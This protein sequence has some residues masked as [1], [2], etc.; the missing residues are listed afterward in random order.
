MGLKPSRI[1]YDARSE[2]ASRE[3]QMMRLQILEDSIDENGKA[4]PLGHQR[5][6]KQLGLMDITSSRKIRYGKAWREVEETQRTQEKDENGLY[7]SSKGWDLLNL[8]EVC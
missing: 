1:V 7:K 6:K 3:G 2:N 5:R 4:T 8:E